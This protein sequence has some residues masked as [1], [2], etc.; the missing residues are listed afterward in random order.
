V[1]MRMAYTAHRPLDGDLIRVFL[2]RATREVTSGTRSI[3]GGRQL[4]GQR[5]RF[6]SAARAGRHKVLGRES[7]EGTCGRPCSYA[8]A[9]NLTRIISNWRQK[10]TVK[11]NSCRELFPIGGRNVQ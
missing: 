2:S 8:T 5:W 11:Y 4:R 10:R 6:N 3:E 7:S 9:D 1:V